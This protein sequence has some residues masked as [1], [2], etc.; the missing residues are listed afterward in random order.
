MEKHLEI[1]E[2]WIDDGLYKMKLKY[3]ILFWFI[4]QKNKIRNWY[5]RKKGKLIIVAAHNSKQK[6]KN[7]A[8]FICDGVDDNITIQYAIN[9]SKKYDR[10]LF[11][12]GEYNM[13]ATMLIPYGRVIGGVK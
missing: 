7:K 10:I 1:K 13:N 12:G 11:E 6:D 4:N 8:D 2:K 9:S 5:F 3:K